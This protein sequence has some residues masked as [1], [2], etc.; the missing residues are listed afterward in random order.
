[1]PTRTKAF[2]DV[3]VMKVNNAGKK[4]SEQG[5]GVPTGHA[6]QNSLISKQL[7]LESFSKTN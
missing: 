6:N 5:I 4:F 7:T 1:M 2:F 3:T